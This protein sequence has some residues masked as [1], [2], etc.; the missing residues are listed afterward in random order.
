MQF[1]SKLS[2]CICINFMKA[3][4]K[5]IYKHT[6]TYINKDMHIYFLIP[7]SHLTFQSLS[8]EMSL[9]TLMCLT[10]MKVFSVFGKQRRHVL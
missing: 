9:N 8:E 4:I 7:P 1:T 6:F 5:Q 3:T 10:E 2:L